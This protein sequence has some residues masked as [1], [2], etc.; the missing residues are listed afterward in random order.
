MEEYLLELEKEAFMTLCEQ[1]K[2]LDRM[3]HILKT[4]KPL[5]N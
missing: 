5:R 2:T 4:G 3:E 1:P